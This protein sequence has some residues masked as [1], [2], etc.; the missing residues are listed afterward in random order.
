MPMG[1]DLNAPGAIEVLKSFYAALNHNDLDACCE[2]FDPQIERVEP[3]GHKTSGV[4]RG[5]EKVRAHIAEGRGTWAEG[6]C[7]PERFLVNGDKVIAY[8][9]VRVRLKGATDWLDGRCADVFTFRNGMIVH[10]RTFWE[11]KEALEWV[12]IDDPDAS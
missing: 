5:R 7:E 2:H 4:H 6:G 3:A 1:E 9:H 10:W 8:V 11:R 12:G